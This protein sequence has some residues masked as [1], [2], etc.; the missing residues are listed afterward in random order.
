MNEGPTLCHGGCY[1]TCPSDGYFTIFCFVQPYSSSYLQT[2]ESFRPLIHKCLDT[3][4]ELRIG[5]PI[6]KRGA[7]SVTGG[8]ELHPETF[9]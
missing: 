6:L 8:Y 5:T 4:H 7:L 2:G 9:N 1:V 3:C